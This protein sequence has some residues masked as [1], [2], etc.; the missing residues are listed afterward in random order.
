MSIYFY[1]V[2]DPFGCFSN[3]AHYGFTLDDKWWMT[4]EHYFQA[5][6]FKNTEFEDMIRLV[7][8]PMKA[9]EIGRNRELPL[10][11]DWE[12]VKDNVMRQAVYAKFSQNLEIKEILLSTKEEILIENTSNDYY[13]G[14]GKNGS[15]KNM[16]GI[17]LM[18]VRELL[19]KT[20]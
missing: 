11:K 15:G 19:N 8:S 1:R 6:K 17:I 4:S 18:E 16:L 14:C 13:W 10:R 9:A 12:K 2:K 20:C 3:F 7:D 5:Q